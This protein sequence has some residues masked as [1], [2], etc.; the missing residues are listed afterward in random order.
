MYVARGF[1][2]AGVR[3]HYTVMRR[4]RSRA[5]RWKRGSRERL[6]RNRSGC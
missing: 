3:E 1:Q 4:Q 6:D 2:A 5:A